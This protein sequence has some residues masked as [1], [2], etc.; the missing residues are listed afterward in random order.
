[1]AGYTIMPVSFLYETQLGR[2]DFSTKEMPK[3]QHEQIACAEQLLYPIKLN[4]FSYCHYQGPNSNWKSLRSLL[5][6]YI[7][8]LFATCP[9]DASLTCNLYQYIYIYIYQFIRHCCLSCITN[10][11]HDTHA[12]TSRLTFTATLVYNYQNLNCYDKEQATKIF[13]SSWR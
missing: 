3:H 4:K 12:F 7:Y 6:F 11:W 10:H 1:M 9:L 2:A 8:S 5:I 13:K